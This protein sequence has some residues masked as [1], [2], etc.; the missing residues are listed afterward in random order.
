MST[1]TPMSTPMPNVP[2]HRRP[3]PVLLGDRLAG[4]RRDLSNGIVTLALVVGLGV[5][6]LVAGLRP[7]TASFTDDG[8]SYEASCG[9]ETLVAGS[10]WD[11][12]DAACQE[13]QGL[14]LLATAGGAVLLL[15]GLGQVALVAARRPAGASPAPGPVRRL[16]GPPAGRLAA[17]GVVVAALVAAG[18]SLVA[19]AR[20]DADTLVGDCS[21]AGAACAGGGGMAGAVRLGALATGLVLIGVLV[22]P[23]LR[24]RGRMLQAGVAL[25]VAGVILLLLAARPVAV[26]T[27]EDLRGTCGV[28][29]LLTG[30]PQPSVTA[31]CRDAM[32]TQGATAAA[33]LV[34]VAVGGFLVWVGRGSGERSGETDQPAERTSPPPERPVRRRPLVAG[35]VSR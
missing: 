11:A 14:R 10:A 27:T 35:E 24:G 34:V 6:F 13:G 1:P 25:V 17:G 28:E 32:T 3:P 16:L 33:G 19:R 9:V 29:V 8:A 26:T 22:W 12:L 30:H 5:V 18:A 4:L 7:T 20:L 21:S 2:V 23:L 15:G 31:A